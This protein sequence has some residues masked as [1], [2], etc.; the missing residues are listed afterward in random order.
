MTVSKLKE[1]S[2]KLI[3]TYDGHNFPV[4]RFFIEQELDEYK[5]MMREFVDKKVR[6]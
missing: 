5:L 2:R 3:Q 4:M 6:I 1:Y